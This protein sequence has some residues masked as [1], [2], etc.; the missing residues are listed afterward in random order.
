LETAIFWWTV[1]YSMSNFSIFHQ[2]LI[3]CSSIGN[4]STLN[5]WFFLNNMFLWSY[6]RQSLF[7]LFF[8][9]LA[10]KSNTLY[11]LC[12]VFSDFTIQIDY[13][14]FKFYIYIIPYIFFLCRAVLFISQN[15]LYNHYDF[16]HNF[17]MV[18]TCILHVKNMVD[19]CSIRVICV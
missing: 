5:F 2:F 14:L 15:F 1:Q 13:F 10:K 7:L 6:T 18:N 12:N 11:K 17:D 4:M 8:I 19:P 3:K 16:S 9:M